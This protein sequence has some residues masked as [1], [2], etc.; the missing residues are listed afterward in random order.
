MLGYLTS[1]NDIQLKELQFEFSSNETWKW[2]SVKKVIVNGLFEML[3]SY[4]HAKLDL[5][6]GEEKWQRVNVKGVDFRV[7]DLRICINFTPCTLHVA[8]FYRFLISFHPQKTW[9]ERR[10]VVQFWNLVESSF[11]VYRM[12]YIMK[13][14]DGNL[15][16][17]RILLGEF[18]RVL[19]FI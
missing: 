14:C 10:L 8:S 13:C 17:F 12:C 11:N 15:V 1:L 18:V 2:F 4:W 9:I 7:Q 16:D 5:Q 19:K 3:I 6:D